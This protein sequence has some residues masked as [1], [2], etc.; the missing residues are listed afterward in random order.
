MTSNATQE[1]VYWHSRDGLR[2]HARR[3]PPA[4]GGDPGRRGTVVC[5]PGLT[6]NAA[7][8]D[9]P[10][11]MMASAGW[12]VFAVDLRG[13][14]GSQRAPNPRSYN[15]R[16]YADDVAGLLESRSIPSAVFVG[17]SLGV[18]VT[19]TLAVRKPALVAGA[20]LNDAGPEVPRE[21]LDRIGRYAGKPVPPM[22]HEAA[23]R[24][25]ESI[26]RTSFPGYGPDDWRAMA[27]RMF[28]ERD[29]GL[30]ELDYDP[31]IVRT[32]NPWV[33]RLMRPLLWRAWRKLGHRRP[34]LVLRGALSDVLAA[35]TARRM[36][37]VADDA[38]LVEV[39]GVGHAPMLTEPEA[40]AAIAAFLARMPSLA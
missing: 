8:F 9:L 3:Y 40:C 6:R 30:L 11:R 10:A 29:D 16:T 17:T 19:M 20:I 26:G 27:R 37:D 7:D 13:R 34:L 15:P 4:T 21:A 31:A 12:Q 1:D 28:R 39:P 32:V 14:A 36:V 2:L 25:V 5:I 22:D 18:L 23:A 24:Y 35:D 33:L 38:R